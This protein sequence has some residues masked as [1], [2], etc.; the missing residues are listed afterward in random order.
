MLC[1]DLETVHYWLAT[2]NANKIKAPWVKAKVET[3]QEGR[4][5]Y[6]ESCRQA[7]IPRHAKG[8][9]LRRADPRGLTECLFG[10]EE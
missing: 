6:R 1:A 10:L 2:I 8:G 5:R 9:R 3:Y 4:T 7:T